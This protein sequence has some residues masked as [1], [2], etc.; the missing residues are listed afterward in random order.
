MASGANSR[1][2]DELRASLGESVA[3]LLVG[4]DFAMPTSGGRGRRRLTGGGARVAAGAGD[5]LHVGRAS[6][7]SGEGMLRDERSMRALAKEIKR[8]ITEDARRGIGF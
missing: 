2:V 6:L 7:S 3:A 8:L 5:K 1:D 4:S